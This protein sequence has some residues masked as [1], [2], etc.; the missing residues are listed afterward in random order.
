MINVIFV[1]INRQSKKDIYYYIVDFSTKICFVYYPNDKNDFNDIN[2]KI[3][4][5][6]GIFSS[7]IFVIGNKQTTDI[8]DKNNEK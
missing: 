8:N 2:V 3:L 4:R 5:N 7:K 1:I 6:K